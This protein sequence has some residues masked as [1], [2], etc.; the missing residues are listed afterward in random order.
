MQ[1]T[2]VKYITRR[3]IVHNNDLAEIGFNGTQV[4][5]VIA[6]TKG[7]VLTIVASDEVFPIL[8]E[9]VDD[10]IGVLLHRGCEDDEFVPFAYLKVGQFVTQVGSGG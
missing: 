9:P 5:D 3:T 8:L 1:R 4:L 7:T 2:F 6:S 10:R